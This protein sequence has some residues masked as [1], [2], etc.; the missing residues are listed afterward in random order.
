MRPPNGAM[1]SS[2]SINLDCSA[3]VAQSWGP[4]FA[5]PFL[6][7]MSEFDKKEIC[8]GFPSAGQGFF[9]DLLR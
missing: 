4:G 6:D 7:S 5:G 1:A 2:Y 8:F 3:F 9:G